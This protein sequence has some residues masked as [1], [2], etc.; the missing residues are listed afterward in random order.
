M[1]RRRNNRPLRQ[2]LDTGSHIKP[3]HDEIGT[4]TFANTGNAALTLNTNLL[5]IALPNVTGPVDK[6]AVSGGLVLNG[7]NKIALVYSGRP[8]S[9]THTIMT[10]A[11]K[12]TD[13]TGTFVFDQAYHP[14]PTLTIGDTSVTV[15]IPGEGSVLRFQ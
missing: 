2:L 9:G 11:S 14:T 1:N 7:T 5:Y 15:T 8:R 6:V 4:L 10:Y 12:T 3:S 13:G